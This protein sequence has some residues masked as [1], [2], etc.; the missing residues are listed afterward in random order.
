MR[1]QDL[2]LAVDTRAHPRI[3]AVAAELAEGLLRQLAHA[4]AVHVIIRIALR[5]AHEAQR[6]IAVNF[7]LSVI[8]LVNILKQVGIEGVEHAAIAVAVLLRHR[9]CLVRREERALLVAVHRILLE[10]KINQKVLRRILDKLHEFAQ[11]RH[12]LAAEFPGEPA[13]RVQGLD[14]LERLFRNGSRAVR[15]AVHR[16]VV[17]DDQPAVLR[18][19]HVQLDHVQ[20]GLQRGPEGRHGILRIPGGK[21]PVPGDVNVID[22]LIPH[23]VYSPSLSRNAADSLSLV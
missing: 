18:A 4:S 13:A 8:F 22:R 5:F 6:I 19:V 9:D 16:M 12:A 11:R 17:H 21:P 23:T 1:L 7:I 2:L 3:H 20:P 10:L 14:F 15:G